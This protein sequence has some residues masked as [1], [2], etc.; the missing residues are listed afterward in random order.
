MQH[1][2][3]HRVEGGPRHR[4]D[5][6]RRQHGQPAERGVGEDQQ[7]VEAVLIERPPVE[8][9]VGQ[10]VRAA[11]LFGVQDAPGDRAHRDRRADAALVEEVHRARADAAAA[12]VGGAERKVRAEQEVG[13]VGVLC[14]RPE[15]LDEELRQR[16]E[17]DPKGGR[18]PERAEPLGDVARRGGPVELQVMN[19]GGVGGAEDRDAG[20][21]VERPAR[22]V[23]ELAEAHRR[24]LLGGDVHVVGHETRTQS[25][26]AAES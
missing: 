15:A 9:A 17:E 3:L 18:G 23:R 16:D 19:A 8:V 7:R 1:P 4:D 14:E 21:E 11:Q 10:P 2:R 25:F 26:C 13:L 20:E 12:A 22:V 5:K 6:V 24:L